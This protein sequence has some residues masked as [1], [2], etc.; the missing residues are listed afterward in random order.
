[1]FQV[2]AASDLCGGPGVSNFDVTGMLRDACAAHPDG[3]L[4][5]FA[6]SAT[7]ARSQKRGKS[8]IPVPPDP[9]EVSTM[10]RP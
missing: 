7:P 2:A 9:S 5:W 6:S 4:W 1:M 8:D 10:T 3:L